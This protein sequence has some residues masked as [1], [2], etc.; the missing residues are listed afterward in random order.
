MVNARDDLTVGLLA[1]TGAATIE[2]RKSPGTVEYP[3]TLRVMEARAAAVAAGRAPELVWLVE[4]PP[5]Y[6][7]GTS[8]RREDLLQA[9]FPVYESGRGGQLTYHG[10]GQRVA[11]VMLDLRRRGAD[12]RRFVATLEEW[13]IRTLAMLAVRGERR[14]DRVGVWVPRVGRGGEQREDKIAAIGI[15]I[16]RWITLHGLALNVDCDL[17]HYSGI[18]PCGVR[19]SRFGVTSLRDLGVAATMADVDAALEPVFHELF[20]PPT[21]VAGSPPELDPAAPRQR[22]GG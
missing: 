16:K 3:D 10:P 4:H 7:A 15:R 1:H 18:V 9:T 17:S 8:T 22:T 11:Y 12:V 21:P 20:G 14:E 13:I 19:E 2:W 6:T 5:L